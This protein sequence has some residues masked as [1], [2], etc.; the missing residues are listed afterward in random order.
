MS[1]KPFTWNIPTGLVALAA[2]LLC[3]LPTIGFMLAWQ[4]LVDLAAYTRFV[5]VPALVLLAVCEYYL[6]RRSPLLFNRFAAGLVGGI[7]ATLVFDLVRYLPTYAMHGAPDYVP[8]IGQY[9]THEMIGI[10]PTTRAVL[11]GYA[12]H[13]VLVGALLG[14]AYSLVVGRGRWVW[15]LV[16]GALA[17]IAFDLLPQAQLLV[18]ATGY[19]L[20]TALGT[21]AIAFLAAGTVMGLVVRRWGAT[22]ANVLSVVFLREHPIEAPDL[23][24]S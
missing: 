12:Y 2:A 1:S 18:T 8:M 14:A 3:V 21:W 22:R 6:T 23:V 9:L 16:L 10:A 4:Q 5:T 19:R 20:E 13:Y 7:V 17:A 11:L 15:G 24:R